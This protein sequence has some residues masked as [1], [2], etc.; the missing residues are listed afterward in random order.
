MPVVR[1]GHSRFGMLVASCWLLKRV[2][3]Y[4]FAAVNQ[5]LAGCATYNQQ[6][7]TNIPANTTETISSYLEYKP[8]ESTTVKERSLIAMLFVAMLAM[9]GCMKNGSSSTAE[10]ATTSESTTAMPVTDPSHRLATF[11]GGCFW[12]MQPPFDTVKGVI[13]TVVG[14][15]GGPEK[16][17]TYQQVSAGRTG[18]TESVQI[19][20][21]PAVVSYDHLLDIFWRNINPTQVNGQFADIG[22][23]YRTAIFPHDAEQRATAERSKKALAASGRFDAPIAVEITDA[24]TFYP[25]EEYHQSYYKKNYDDYARYR[26]GSGRA[27]YLEKTWATP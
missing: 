12:C 4:L 1:D 5:V 6:P 3:G 21:D 17:P 25:A 14:Y 27:G 15:T 9:T 13:R 18:H 20:Y 26:V 2:I 16:D 22:S 24:S 11:A 7:T 23:Q 10:S 8:T 19:T